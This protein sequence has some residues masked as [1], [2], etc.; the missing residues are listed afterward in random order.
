MFG[1]VSDERKEDQT[2]ESG[3]SAKSCHNLCGEEYAPL[4][5][6]PFFSSLVDTADQNVGT[7]GCNDGDDYKPYSCTVLIH[8]GNL[9]L[10]LA[11]LFKQGSV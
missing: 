10:L 6:V 7:K 4:G 11:L 2:D 8:V 9:F 3:T 5:D 1:S